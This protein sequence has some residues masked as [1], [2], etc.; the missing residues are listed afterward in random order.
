MSRPVEEL[1]IR[2][3]RAEDRDAVRDLTLNAY[4]EYAGVMAPSAWTGLDQA[5]RSAL[6]SEGGRVERMVAEMDGRI[7]GSVMLYPSATD[8]YG[9]AV[10][11]ASWP[12]LRL[13]A[14][15]P[16][17]R[18][19]GVGRMLVEECIRRARRSGASGLGL[20]TSRS[21]VSAI[22]M[23]RQMGFE[24]APEHDFRP[25]GAELVEA[26]RLRIDDSSAAP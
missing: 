9:G 18:G 1:R 21:M 4:A 23:Y 22:R 2:D 11:G 6:A 25:Q 14:V 13:L 17:A 8:A 7:V 24:R 15:A 3:A 16:V 5:I 10:Q 26:F 20:H 19:R 12:E